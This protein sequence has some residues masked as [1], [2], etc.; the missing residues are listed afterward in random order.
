M[1]HISSLLVFSVFQRSESTHVN[2]VAHEMV[3]TWLRDAGIPVVA[4][5]GK[6]DGTE[7]LSILVDGFQHRSVVERICREYKQECY[8]ELHPD[9]FASLVFLDGKRRDLG[10]LQSVPEHEALGADG[11]L[12]NPRSGYFIVR[13]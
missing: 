12:Y 9:R 10:M 11:Y 4:L 1:R 3:L 5:R 6:Y 8:I 13:H 7:E 2:N